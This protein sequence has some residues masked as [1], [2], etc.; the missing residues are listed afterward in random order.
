GLREND[1]AFVA[2]LLDQDVVARREIDVVG[3]VT[4]GRRAHVLGVERVLEREHDAV[5]R[6]LVERRVRAIA[7]VER[8]SGFERVG[9]IPEDFADRR[10]A[11]RQ[12]ALGRVAVEFALAGNRTLAADVQG[13]ERV[14]LTGIRLAGDHAVLLQYRGVGGGWLH[15]AEF[16]RRA[17]VLVEIGEDRRGCDGFG[18]KLQWRAGT[19][20]AG[21]FGDAPTILGDEQAG[22][23]VVGARPGDVVLHDL[24]TGCFAGPDRRVQ[25]VDRRFF[26]AKRLPRFAVLV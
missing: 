2:Q 17:L 9:Q 12:R 1:R 6:H 19:H 18:R 11:R 24:N 21:R 3:G 23:P 10:R 5:H 14:E 8:G 20:R 13:R 15:A 25:F 16:E 22:D 7:G 26:K 4:S